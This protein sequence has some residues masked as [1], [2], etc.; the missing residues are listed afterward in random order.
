MHLVRAVTVSFLG[1]L[2]AVLAISH[3]LISFSVQAVVHSLPLRTG[4][5]LTSVPRAVLHWLLFQKQANSAE[6][7]AAEIVS[8]ILS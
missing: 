7:V 6:L 1:H 2:R 5:S 4:A 3:L 8:D